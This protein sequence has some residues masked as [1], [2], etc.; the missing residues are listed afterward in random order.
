MKTLFKA[1]ALVIF[2]LC[3]AF[4][5]ASCGE[6]T[7]VT[8]KHGISRP[9]ECYLTE[10]II[11]SQKPD[12]DKLWGE[13]GESGLASDYAVSIDTNSSAS[14]AVYLCYLIYGKSTGSQSHIT[15][16]VSVTR[17]KDMEVT[18]D[19]E[20]GVKI[21]LIQSTGNVDASLD[22]TKESNKRLSI[23]CDDK[24]IDAALLFKISVEDEGFSKLYLDLSVSGN[25]TG[26]THIDSQ[27]EIVIGN[28]DK[29]T[30]HSVEISNISAR[31]IGGASYNNGDY[32]QYALNDTPTFSQDKCY[33]ILSF[34]I[35]SASGGNVNVLTHVGNR[36]ML[37]ATIEE[38][39]TG[40]IEEIMSNNTSKMYAAYTAPQS[41]GEIK[42]VTMTVRLSLVSGGETDLNIFFMGGDD[43]M[44]VGHTHKS[45]RVKTSDPTLKYE[46]SEDKQSYTVTGLYHKD[47]KNIVIPDE[48][49]DGLPVVAIGRDV[50]SGNTSITTL[51]IGNNIR[52]IPASAFK[53]CSSLTTVSLGSSIES[54]GEHAFAECTML[55]GITI[56]ESVKHLG[57]RAFFGCKSLKFLN[58]N[59]VA[60]DPVD[61]K[62]QIFTSCG[63]SKITIGKD[64]QKLPTFLFYNQGFVGEVVISEGCRIYESDES[65][66]QKFFACKNLKSV[67]VH[68]G[69]IFGG[70]FSGCEALESLY[71]GKNVTGI[72]SNAFYN[73]AS[74]TNVYYNAE[75]ASVYE[76]FTGRVM[77][78]P[79]KITIGK[80][81][82][83]IGSGLFEELNVVSVIFEEGSRCERIYERAFRASALESINLPESLTYIYNYAFS[84]TKLTEITIPG[85]AVLIGKYAFYNCT[86]LNEVNIANVQTIDEYA[87]LNCKTLDDINIAAA[88]HIKDCAFSGCGEE[89]KSVTL[90]INIKTLGISIFASEKSRDLYYA[91]SVADWCRITFKG[92]VFDGISVFHTSEGP[93]Y[94]LIIPEGVTSIPDYAFQGC[95]TIRTVKVESKTLTHVGKSAFALAN[96]IENADLG[97]ALQTIGDSAFNQCYSIVNLTLPVALKSIGSDAFSNAFFSSSKTRIDYNGTYSQWKL[98]TKA[99]YWFKGNVVPVCCT[100]G[101]YNVL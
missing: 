91:G 95:G 10:A 63:I 84:D 11:S 98:I 22:M 1:L 25:L 54:I 12:I 77:Q 69:E 59:A 64:V 72:G 3:T 100:D 101:T 35:T 43:T 99:D 75:N 14:N 94:T 30:Q 58:Y 34:N 5:L 48:L 61:Y 81:T 8:D 65:Q 53:G 88:D 28:S 79:A 86:M 24:C 36:G 26:T 2:S 78:S 29:S 39:P 51:Q 19:A 92:S 41:S 47:Q 32:N 15:T 67:T 40:K 80:D 27:N 33:M 21:S 50:F 42:Q 20:S 31:F 90:P 7:S 62:A 96:H 93:A 9:E 83:T 85:N 18:K 52:E 87:F 38:A 16:N 73:C 71:I 82:V 6:A 46:L 57:D 89:G 66:K 55:T 4:A 68:S 13:G 45:I 70:M 49:Y 60:C 56:V 37:S 97:E 23:Y 74:L 44:T 17:V 76:V